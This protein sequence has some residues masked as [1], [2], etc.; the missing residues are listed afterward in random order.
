ML[1]FLGKD[2]VLQEVTKADLAQADPEN[3][4]KV[5]NRKA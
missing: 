5:W 1:T 4:T 3:K 2:F